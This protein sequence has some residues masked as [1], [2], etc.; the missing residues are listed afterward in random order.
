MS[1]LNVSLMTCMFE[2]SRPSLCVA[3]AQHLGPRDFS[4]YQLPH[5]FEAELMLIKWGSEIC[6]AQGIHSATW[7]NILG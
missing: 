7:I 3:W 1:D 4:A 6:T 2:L 5:I